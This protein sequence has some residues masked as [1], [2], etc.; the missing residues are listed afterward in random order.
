MSFQTTH[1]KQHNLFCIS[2]SFVLTHAVHMLHSAIEKKAIAFY[3]LVFTTDLLWIMNIYGKY[4][5]MQYLLICHASL[6][7]EASCL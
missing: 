3:A 6:P 4:Y 1:C 2:Y 7:L 5:V